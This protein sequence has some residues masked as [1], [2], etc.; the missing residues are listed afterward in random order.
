[1]LSWSAARRLKD[2]MEEEERSFRSAGR[3]AAVYNKRVFASAVLDT[4]KLIHCGLT[5]AVGGSCE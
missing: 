3:F 2:A 5:G 4:R 1:M